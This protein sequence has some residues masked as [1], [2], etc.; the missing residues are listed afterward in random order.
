VFVYLGV[1]GLEAG[2]RFFWREVRGGSG[3]GAGDWR[4]IPPASPTA[5]TAVARVHGDRVLE[6]LDLEL[7]GGGEGTGRRRGGRA[8]VWAVS[9]PNALG[10][11]RA[12]CHPRCIMRSAA[13][14]RGGAAG[15]RAAWRAGRARGRAV[16]GAF[17]GAAARRAATRAISGPDPHLWREAEGAARAPRSARARQCPPPP[18]PPHALPT[19][20]TAFFLG[21]PDMVAPS[22]RARTAPPRPG[23]GVGPAP[24][25]RGGAGGGWGAGRARASAGWWARGA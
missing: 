9:R 17:A 20:L 14:R 6:R 5:R 19:L 8:R 11:G 21:A 3:A 22:S 18:F 2:P 23:S 13:D 1:G 25:A 15:T 12:R 10:S 7:R 4:A 24:A 16:A